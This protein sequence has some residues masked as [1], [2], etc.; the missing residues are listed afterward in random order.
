MGGGESYLLSLVEHLD[1]EIFDPVVL[2]FTEGPMVDQLKSMGIPTHVIHSEKPFDISVWRKVR[3]LME[4][5]NIELV[6]AHGTRACSNMYR[7]SNRLGI[8]LIYTC[9]GWSFH[10]DQSVWVRKM[11]IK[12]EQLLTRKADVNIC[13]SFANRETGKKLFKNFDAEVIHTSINTQKFNASGSYKDVRKELGIPGE[14]LLF[15]YIA[16][17]TY[18]KQPLKMVEAF[19]RVEKSLPSAQ[20]LMVGDGE[21]SP[22]VK[23]KIQSLGLGEKIILQPFRQDIPDVLYATDIFVLPSLWEGFPIALVEAMAMGKVVI[24]TNVD[25]T[26]EIVQHEENGLL[27]GTDAI[28]EDL[29][30]AM[31]RLG[32][33]NDLRQRLQQQAI[34]TTQNLFNVQTMVNQNEAIY[35][36]LMHK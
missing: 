28:V 26:P 35:K 17:F 8:P 31:I 6:H 21:E 11:R 4:Q 13:V 7:A 9:H 34:S 25:G 36:R 15:A 1:K 33:D 23:E 29:S 22:G 16:R 3:R 14:A 2:S 5:E 12:G 30:R 20:L 32:N 10:P 18:Q 24:A 27:I 19:A